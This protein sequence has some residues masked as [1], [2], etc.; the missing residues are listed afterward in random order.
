MAGLKT[1]LILARFSGISL[2]PNI[3]NYTLLRERWDRRYRKSKSAPESDERRTPG[4]LQKVDQI[5][6]G[7]RFDFERAS[8]EALFLAPDLVRI[9]W[10]PGVPPLPY[11]LAKTDWPPVEAPLGEYSEGYRL[12]G[13]QAQILVTEYGGLQLLDASGIMLRDE[14]PPEQYGPPE[15]PEQ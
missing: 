15:S 1:V 8:L 10:Q 12:A 11:A 13:P 2:L 7:A 14:A 5:E 4:R 3:L 6:G 9:S